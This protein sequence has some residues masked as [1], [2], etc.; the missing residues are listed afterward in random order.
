VALDR[1]ARFRTAA[2]AMKLL[3]LHGAPAAGK[4][5]VAKAAARHGAGAAVRQS[6]GGRSGAHCVRLRRARLLGAG[7]QPEMRDL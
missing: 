3:F 7:A 5:T 6:R 4:L 2:I 1:N